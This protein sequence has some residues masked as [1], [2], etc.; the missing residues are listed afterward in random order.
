MRI[1]R[2]ETYYN[3]LDSYSRQPDTP[4]YIAMMIDILVVRLVCRY[5]R[6]LLGN[7][8]SQYIYSMGSFTTV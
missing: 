5:T 3:T 4:V 8:L 7:T 1:H 2:L 6:Q